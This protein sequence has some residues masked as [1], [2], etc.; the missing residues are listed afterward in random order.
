LKQRILLFVGAVWLLVFTPSSVARPP[1]LPAS[2]ESTLLL[3]GGAQVIEARVVIREGHSV[4]D[5]VW[6]WRP[7][8]SAGLPVKMMR[9]FVTTDDC[10][11]VTGGKEL[12]ITSSGD[13]VALVSHQT[14]A[15]LFYAEVKN[16]HSAELLPNG[17]IAVASS[18][19]P[20]HHGDRLL[21]FDRKVSQTPVLSIPLEA[22]HGVAWDSRRQVLWA[23]GG[24]VLLSIRLESAAGQPQLIVEKQIPLPS[25]EGHDLQ[26][27]NDGSTLY[28][29]NTKEVFRFDPDR[30]DF[31]P[32]KPFQGEGEIKSLSIQPVT[33]QIAYTRADPGVWW[34][35]T[36]HFKDPGDHITV[37]SMIYKVRWFVR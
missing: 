22:A 3:C 30:L 36:I 24:A 2:A 7:E 1:A 33:G 23:L 37:P 14:G 32:F 13:A 16:A 34:T 8:Q 9:K 31:S 17:Y 11:A 4:L 27:A 21:L 28:I 35:Y 25:R 12:L 19:D 10:K 26:L 29:T 6:H 15:T 20:E 18:S 5:E